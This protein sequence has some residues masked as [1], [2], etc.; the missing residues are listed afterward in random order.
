MRIMILLTRWGLYVAHV[1]LYVILFEQVSNFI[2]ES[3]QE[4]ISGLKRMAA[5]NSGVFV[6][7]IT[8]CFLFVYGEK[9][10]PNG[11]IVGLLSGIAACGYMYVYY[12]IVYIPN[13]SWIL[14]L[15]QVFMDSVS[16]LNLVSLLLLPMI[17]GYLVNIRI[18]RD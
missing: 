15:T 5:F 11:K 13:Q 16:F 18:R 10:R 2:L 1:L 7:L 17:V 4:P 12:P 14:T 6:G 3:M 9:I 8:L